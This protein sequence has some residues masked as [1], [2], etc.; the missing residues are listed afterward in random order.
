MIYGLADAKRHLRLAQEQQKKQYDKGRRDIEFS[1]GQQ[2]LLSSKNIT[3]R[4]I[5]DNAAT[6]KLMPKWIGPFPIEEVIGKGAY[7]LTLPPDMRAHNVFS[8]VSLRPYHSD[9]RTQPP[10]PIL[11]DDQEKF[12]VDSFADHRKAGRSYQYLVRWQGIAQ[13]TTRGSHRRTS[14]I[15][16][17]SNATGTL[18]GWNPPSMPL[19]RRQSRRAPLRWCTRNRPPSFRGTW[20]LRDSPC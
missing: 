13:N 11:I 14:K 3:L 5:G 1:V 2:V 10:Q 17:R 20:T 6:P 8:V 12:V 19:A 9:G 4:R 15:S 18:S 7:R 16:K